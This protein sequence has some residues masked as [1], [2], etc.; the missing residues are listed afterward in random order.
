LG[1]LSPALGDNEVDD[2]EDRFRLIGV[3]RR[4]MFGF[5]INIKIRLL[6]GV[7]IRY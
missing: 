7:D 2:V 6:T 4:D 5:Y 3:L 1:F